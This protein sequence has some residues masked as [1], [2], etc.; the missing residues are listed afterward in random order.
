MFIVQ[1]DVKTKP[2]SRHSK[3][4]RRSL[5]PATQAAS[6]TSKIEELAAAKIEYYMRRAQREEERH[7]LDVKV[8]QPQKA[9]YA[10]KLNKAAEC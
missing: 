3:K 2:A 5:V 7:V 9:Y 6:V 8:L 10:S 1:V 4:L